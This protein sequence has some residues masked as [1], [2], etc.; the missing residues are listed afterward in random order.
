MTNTTVG[1]LHPGQMGIS[2]AASVQNGG[3]PVYWAS[4]GRSAGSRT[5]AE[6]HGLRDAGT[7]AEL[8]AACSV[9]ISVCPPAAAEELAQEVLAH[10]FTGLYVDANAI[11]PQRAERIAAA[12]RRGGARFVDGSIIG[13]PAWKPGTTWLYLSG[14]DAEEAAALFA[15]GPAQAIALGAE[16][17]RASALKMVY[18]AYTK[19]STALL[20]ASLG[21]ADALG[22]RGDLTEQWQREGSGMDENAPR[23]ARGV[24][25]K[26]W[27]F[28]G[29]MEEIAATF[30]EAGLPGGFH[31]AAADVYRRLARFKDATE[32]PPLEDVFAA[33]LDESADGL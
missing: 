25:A 2:I 27:R 14:P 13:P 19:G 23:R 10:G 30:E 32:T 21:A 11:S 12:V 24:T 6:Q 20:A 4:S 9:V 5:R 26:A 22:V 17:G 28:V 29:E 3:H 33:L 18:A 7:L 1:I 8:C 15:A 31:A 16:I